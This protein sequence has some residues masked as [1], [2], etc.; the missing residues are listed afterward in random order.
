MT[1]AYTDLLSWNKESNESW[2]E[3]GTYSSY[4]NYI[5]TQIENTTSIKSLTSNLSTLTSDTYNITG[6]PV[7]SHYKGVVIKNGKKVLQ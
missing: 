6:Q 7:D 5:I 3:V 1:L 4:Q 2:K